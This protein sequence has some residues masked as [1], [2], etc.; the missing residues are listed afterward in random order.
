L[1]VRFRE[2]NFGLRMR[3]RWMT[4]RS[5]VS[6]MEMGGA[7]RFLPQPASWPGTPF[8]IAP[9]SESRYGAPNFVEGLD[10]GHPPTYGFGG[11]AGFGIRSVHTPPNTIVFPTK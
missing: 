2:V 6:A 1:N 10:V 4:S 8:A 9:I 11:G 5:F 3:C 7:E